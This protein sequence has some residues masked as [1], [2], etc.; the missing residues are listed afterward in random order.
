MKRRRLKLKQKTQRQI[1]LFTSPQRHKQ[2]H[3]AASNCVHIHSQPPSELKSPQGSITQL[4]K[5]LTHP[6][7]SSNFPMFGWTSEHG[8]TDFRKPFPR[9]R[10]TI[11]L[12]YNILFYKVYLIIGCHL[13]PIPV[14]LRRD[15]R[16]RSSPA[17]LILLN[18]QALMSPPAMPFF[19][20]DREMSAS[21]C[22]FCTVCTICIKCIVCIVQKMTA[23]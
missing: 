23:G 14:S 21:V 22:M 1:I 18:T 4:E 13:L 9:P 16:C 2:A 5:V 17:R 8:F 15:F 12:Y 11:C 6:G 10:R 3:P 20:S 7:H 19:G